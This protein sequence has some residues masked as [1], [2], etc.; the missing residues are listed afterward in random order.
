MALQV[1]SLLALLEQFTCFTSTKVQLLTPSALQE[2]CQH[3]YTG[4]CSR[5]RTYAHVCSRMLTYA[6]VC[7]S[8]LTYA[9]VC[10]RMLTYAHVC[11]RMLTYAHVCSRMLTY[12]MVWCVCAMY[13]GVCSRTYAHVCWRMLQE[14][15]LLEAEAGV[16]KD[17]VCVLT[18]A[19]VC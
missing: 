8:M 7:S 18:Y 12:A 13:A 16:Y 5:M 17:L 19:D 3:T 11:A 6:H 4:G 15:R 10:S 2:Q 1:L 9:H 14:Q